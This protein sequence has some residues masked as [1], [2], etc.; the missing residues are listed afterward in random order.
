M[1]VGYAKFGRSIQFDPAKYGPQ[2]DPEAPQLLRRLAR[3]NPDHEF[4]VIGKNS[5]W[6]KA[7][8]PPN[9]TNLWVPEVPK[10][11]WWSQGDVWGCGLCKTPNDGREFDC[12]DRARWAWA[13]E[14]WVVDRIAEL[15]GVVL[16]VGQH[17]TSSIP[18][19]PTAQ[20][21]SRGV[22]TK[23]YV[24]SR[25]YGGY[26][27]EGVNR[28][29]DQHD[30][31]VPIVWICVDPRNYLKARDIK[32]PTG[33]DDI[34][35]QFAYERPG[36]HERFLDPRRPRELGVTGVKTARDGELWVATH[37]YRHGGTELMIIPDDWETWGA[38]GFHDRQ[39]VGIAS[40]SAY[41]PQ[42]ERR[43]SWQIQRWVVDQFPDAEV[44]GRWDAKSLQDVTIEVKRNKVEEFPDILGSWR[45]TLSLPPTTRHIGGDRWSVAKPYQAFAARTVCFLMEPGDAPG[46]V[47]PSRL[48]EP[49]ARQVADGL[50][51]VRDGWTDEELHLARWLRVGTPEEFAKR[52]R[53]VVDDESTWTW[54]VDA[55]RR[56]LKRHWDLAYLERTI[57]WRLGL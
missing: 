39:P 2:G 12:C 14:R 11:L 18:I 52:A 26:L 29:C 6:D 10:A 33:T 23:P 54:L 42:P 21:W 46:W 53:A 5:G 47:L 48:R 16:H 51:S 27:V 41:V 55:Q 44:F 25:N 45:V 4:V 40:T 15:D 57:E 30:G 38:K 3:R 7:E 50:W 9:V 1:K 22:L 17:G 28:L 24:E 35:A 49:G 20:P 8:M 56:L 37:R 31:R 36:K 43:R 32:W 34:L 19:T 13:Y